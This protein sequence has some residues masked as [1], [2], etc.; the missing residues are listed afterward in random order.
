VP[1]VTSVKTNI[2]IIGN[3]IDMIKTDVREVVFGGDQLTAA[4]TRGASA[5][6]ANHE[7]SLQQ[8][9]DLFPVIENWHTRMTLM[10]VYLSNIKQFHLEKVV[11]TKI[12]LQQRN[13][14]PT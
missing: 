4:Q 7:T 11:H 5:I 10:K 14:I 8:L 2:L 13:S 3:K 1:T 12:Q 9:K 6:R